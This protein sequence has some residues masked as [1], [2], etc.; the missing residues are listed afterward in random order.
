MTQ[1][2]YIS[3]K[4]LLGKLEFVVFMEAISSNDTRPEPKISHEEQPYFRYPIT[5]GDYEQD[6]RKHHM[7]NVYPGTDITDYFLTGVLHTRLVEANTYTIGQIVDK[8]P[9]SP[10]R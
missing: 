6:R 4:Q 5:I 8:I 3:S 2:Y 10:S 9:P 7:A 1:L